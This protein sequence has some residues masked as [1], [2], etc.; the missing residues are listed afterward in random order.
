MLTPAWGGVLGQYVKGVNFFMGIAIASAVVD[1]MIVR[2]VWG[3][4]IPRAE[5]GLVLLLL[6]LVLLLLLDE[7]EG[8]GEGVRVVVGAWLVG[9]GGALG[10]LGCLFCWFGGVLESEALKVRS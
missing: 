7:R 3:R 6:V 10:V 9:V 8:E 5:E 4:E 2:G 1:G